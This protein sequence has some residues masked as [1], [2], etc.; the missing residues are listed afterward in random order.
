MII[1]CT[2]CKKIICFLLILDIYILQKFLLSYIKASLYS[3]LFSS[4]SVNFF[5]FFGFLLSL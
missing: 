3:R 2:K 4:K 5:P 1:P